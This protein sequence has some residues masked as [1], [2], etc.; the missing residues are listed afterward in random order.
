[1][2]RKSPLLGPLRM[3]ARWEALLAAADVGRA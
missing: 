3:D 1:M 2:I